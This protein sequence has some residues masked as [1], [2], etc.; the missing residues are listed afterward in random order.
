MRI[1]ESQREAIYKLWEY[2][3]N[4]NDKEVKKYLEYLIELAPVIE[5]DEERFFRETGYELYC[6]STNSDL[7]DR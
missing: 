7:Y 3:A 5:M 2:V 6:G 4:E 1:T